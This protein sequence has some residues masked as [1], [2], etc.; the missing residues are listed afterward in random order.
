MHFFKVP[1]LGSYLAIRL[2]YKSCLYEEALDSAVT[3]YLDVK[4]R[5]RIQEEEKRSFLEKQHDDKDHEDPDQT[6]NSSVLAT[7]RKWEEIKPKPF[8]TQ[9]VQYVVCLNTMGQDREFTAD[10]IKFAQ[11]T[12]RDFAA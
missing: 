5:Q 8:K 4:E 2:E 3:D 12:I 6:V 1:K 10:E 7:S 9:N 11:R